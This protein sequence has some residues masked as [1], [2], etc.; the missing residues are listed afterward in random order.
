MS[1]SLQPHGLQHA[2]L[3]CPS[4]SPRVG[5][6][7]VHR[8]CDAIQPSH[9]LLSP[10]PPVRNLSQHQSLF[11]WVSSSHQVAKLLELQLQ[12]L[13]FQW[14]FILFSF[15]IDWL[16]FLAVKGALKSI[17]QDHSSKASILQ[18][19]AFLM[20]QLL[21]PYMTTGKTIAFLVGN[22]SAFSYTV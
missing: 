21:H 17:L 10:S 6:S 12:H 9:P 7:H 16:P 15:R 1:N 3:P 14:I 22:V 13:S 11:W 2:T 18:H 8:V 19:S 4:P 20:V 5:Q